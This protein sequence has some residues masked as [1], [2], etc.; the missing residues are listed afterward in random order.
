LPGL[1]DIGRIKSLDDKTSEF[2]AVKNLVSEFGS[3]PA[4]SSLGRGHP[5]IGEIGPPAMF[6]DLGGQK[7]HPGIGS[8]GHVG[9]H[10]GIGQLGP[11][12]GHPGLGMLPPSTNPPEDE[13]GVIR[14]KTI[15]VLHPPSFAE[16]QSRPLALAMPLG[17][18]PGTNVIKLFPPVIYKHS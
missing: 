10:P 11:V 5:G 3:H 18:V 12:K 14:V 15:G 4:I 8:L 13:L 6:G 7:G 1:R 2:G 17:S 9:G 16:D